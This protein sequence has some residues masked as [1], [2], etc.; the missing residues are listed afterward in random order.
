[1]QAT[2]MAWVVAFLAFMRRRCV[3][4]SIIVLSSLFVAMHWQPNKQRKNSAARISDHLHQQC[5]TKSAISVYKEELKGIMMLQQV[6]LL[7]ILC[8]LTMVEAKGAKMMSMSQQQ[9]NITI[10]ESLLE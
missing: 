3:N 10:V 9:S 2:K 7:V 8:S 1:M 4:A 6:T 5:V